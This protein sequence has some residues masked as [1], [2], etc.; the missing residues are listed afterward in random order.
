MGPGRIARRRGPVGTLVL[1]IAAACALPGVAAAADAP[2]PPAP[3][4]PAA[5]APAP[6][7][8]PLRDGVIAPG[9]SIAG[10]DVSG[11]TAQAARAAV[12]AG[13][14]GP[15]LRRLV[16]DLNGRRFGID[17]RTAGYT[18][19]L[20]RAIQAA[21]T[22]G[23]SQ[24]AR[25]VN[26]PLAERVDRGRLRAVLAAKAKDVEVVPVDATLSF[27]NARPVVRPARLGEAVALDRAVDLVAGALVTR[28]H[29]DYP[30]PI[31][32]VR[33]AVGSVGSALVINRETLRLSLYRGERLVRTFPVATGMASFPTPRGQ[34]SIITK[35]LNPTWF[36]PSS[37]WAA[38]LG[39]IPPGPGNPLGTRWMGTSAPAVGIHGTNASS[40]I[41]THASHGCIRMFIHDAE[42]LYS[43]VQVGTPIL[44][45]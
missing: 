19:D 3:T 35:Q 15:K 4:A 40:S 16:V 41:G 21:L 7:G 42:W 37:P 14:L 33:P 9:V 20:D 1:A 39:P 17:P 22:F 5:P 36:P 13:A 30:L 11:D 32:R 10:V 43:R 26:V 23:R 25:P 44:I 29:P 12:L 24:P 38:G 18:A 6:P 34:F 28:R 31:Q 8:P 27:R 45:V 2:A